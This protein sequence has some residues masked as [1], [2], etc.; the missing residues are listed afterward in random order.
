[1]SYPDPQNAL[2]DS[3]LTSPIANFIVSNPLGLTPLGSNLF[4]SNLFASNLLDP[5]SSSLLS[6]SDVAA[7]DFVGDTLSTAH[8]FGDANGATLQIEDSV[9]GTDRYDFYRFRLGTTA[10]IDLQLTKLVADADLQLLDSQ[11]NVLNSSLTFGTSDEAIRRSLDAGV[12]YIRVSSFLSATTAYRLNL[13]VPGAAIDPGLSF[14]TARDFGQLS[15]GSRTWDD[16]VGTT[17]PIDY[18]RFELQE[19]SQFTLNLTGLSSDLDVKLFDRNGNSLAT[20]AGYATADE[21][22]TQS[23]DAGVY[24]IRVYP[25][26]G[27][28]KYRL[29]VGTTTTKPITTTQTLRGTL[30]AD[31]FTFTGNYS[32]TIVSGN[33]NVDFGQ[34]RFDSLDLSNLRSTDVLFNFASTT[35]GGMLYDP[36]TG[37]RLFDSIMLQNGNE[38]LFEGI[39]RLVFSD[40]TID[41]FVT[42]NDPLFSGQWNLHMMGV[43]TAWQFGTGTA[44]VLIGVQDT[45]LGLSSTGSIHP[46]LRT[47]IGSVQNYEDDYF[48]TYPGPGSGQQ[49]RSHGTDVQSIIAAAS[50]NGIGMSGINWNSPVFTIDVLDGNADDE[51]LATATQ[52]MINEAN[53]RGQRLVINMSL[54]GGGIDPLFTA[55]VANNQNTALFVIASGNDDANRLDNP[56]VLATRYSN[57]IAV[58][59][60]WGRIDAYGNGSTPGDRISYPSWWGSNYGTGLTLMAPSEVTAAGANYSSQVG[61]VFTYDSKFNGTSAATPNVTGV[62]SLVWSANPLLTATQVQQI[63]SQTAVDLGS[64]GYD[65]LTGHGMINADAAVRRALAIARGATAGTTTGA[66]TGVIV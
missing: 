34:N 45:G 21:S 59:A 29:T 37:S 41:R 8:N 35:T 20:S 40:R 28:S 51:S 53:R 25:W 54:G 5:S 52:A 57:V 9:S 23:L 19:S 11:G 60:S 42:P 66:T 65:I 56:A 39:E 6:S 17:D 1:M 26:S 30:G 48:R 43:Q 27:S 13:T 14:D 22:I 61:A 15:R 49:T 63:L 24:Y 32:R 47:P 64:A 58:G 7:S 31:T 36:G 16:S 46:D 3:L 55:L 33:G 50:N 18:Y 2:M 38:I 62:A 12:Y 10:A 4:A 44:D